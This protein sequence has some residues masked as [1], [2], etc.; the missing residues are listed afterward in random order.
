MAA[1][2]GDGGYGC[3]FMPPRQCKGASSRP[4][5]NLMDNLV[6]K[7]FASETDAR[8]EVDN[9]AVVKKLDPG[10]DWSLSALHLCKVNAPMVAAGRC[11]ALRELKKRDHA[12]QVIMEYGGNT[13][14]D[15]WRKHDVVDLVEQALRGLCKLHHAGYVHMDVKPDNLLVH[16]TGRLRLID[17]GFLT[18]TSLVY[19]IGHNGYNLAYDYPYFPPEFSEY[20]LVKMRLPRKETA[21]TRFVRRDPDIL[22]TLT[23]CVDSWGLGTSLAEMFGG[24]GGGPLAGLV[25]KMTQRSP[26]ARLSVHDALHFVQNLSG[27]KA[28]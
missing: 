8:H 1:I 16:S 18:P 10:N 19:D 20:Y 17:F 5:L 27:K 13:L 4:P 25:S 12:H 7:V 11:P 14:R 3:V 26:K 6:G 9:Y 28:K 24:S 2:I 21:L 23:G 22:C 15:A